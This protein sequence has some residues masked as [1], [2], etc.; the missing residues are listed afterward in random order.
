MEDEKPQPTYDVDSTQPTVVYL[1]EE[2]TTTTTVTHS[3]TAS[4]TAT[5]TAPDDDDQVRPKFCFCLFILPTNQNLG[6]ITVL[7]GTNKQTNKTKQNKTKQ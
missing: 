5:T 3:V 2:T 7:L 1:G 4:A 6:R